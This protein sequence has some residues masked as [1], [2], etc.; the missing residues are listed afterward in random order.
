VTV[1]DSGDWMRI[2]SY[3]QPAQLNA[4]QRLHQTRT[5]LHERSKADISTW[6]NTIAGQRKQRLEAKAK[7]E[8]DKEA[9]QVKL[10]LEEAKFQAQQR[11]A[12]I[13]RAKVQMFRQTDLVKTFESAQLLTEV[14]NERSRQ[15]NFGEH[16]DTLRAGVETQ[17]QKSMYED[18]RAAEKEEMEK[19]SQAR[20]NAVDTAAHQLEEAARHRAE[21]RATRKADLAQQAAID[22]DYVNF[23]RDESE[24]DAQNRMKGLK[25]VSDR[26]DCDATTGRIRNRTALLETIALEKANLAKTSKDEMDERRK[27]DE[28]AARKE[29]I[30]K[31]ERLAESLAVIEEDNS[32]EESR[33]IREAQEQKWKADDEREAQ[34]ELTRRE[35]IAEIKVH[36]NQT[37]AE[38]RGMVEAEVQADRRERDETEADLRAAAE[39]EAAMLAEEKRRGRLILKSYDADITEHMQ[40]VSAARDKLVDERAMMNGQLDWEKDA[41][42]RYAAKQVTRS[43][44]EGDTMTYPIRKAIGDLT[45]GNEPKP[46]PNLPT[47]D[48][49]RRGNPYPNNTKLRMGFNF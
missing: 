18:I 2:M 35:V 43:T 39:H 14:I 23:I 47:V 4:S 10:D 11:K 34:K 48:T 44:E 33:R 6:T 7:R 36:R 27:A 31:R 8:S 9:R 16:R 12:A 5:Q 37:I 41:F 3:N 21:R 15:G 32:A 40:G 20:A 17:R 49:R 25:L 13:T 46:R 42:A 24:K 45:R 1:L 38:R 28:L 22:L 29:E 30:L 26:H 19:M